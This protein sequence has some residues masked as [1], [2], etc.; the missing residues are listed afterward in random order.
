VF[1]GAC[2]PLAGRLETVRKV[3]TKIIRSAI[4]RPASGR[5]PSGTHSRRDDETSGT[6]PLA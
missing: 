3:L 5:E 2:G 6:S 1:A 4:I